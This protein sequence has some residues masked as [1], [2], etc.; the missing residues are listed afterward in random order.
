MTRPRALDLFCG[1]G[2]AAMGLHRAGF[3]IVGIDIEPQPNYPFAFIQADALAPPFDLSQFDFIWASPPCQFASAAAA[4]MRAR[5][6]EYPDLID[7][8]R[9][10]LA[11]SGA[12]TAME[13]V[14]QAPLRRDLIL[15]GTMFPPLR[16][17]RRRVFETN[18]FML[19][20]SSRVRP[21]LVTKERWST[22]A[23]GGR[24]SGVPVEANAWHTADACRKAMGIDWMPRRELSQAIPPAYSEFIGRAAL[25]HIGAPSPNNAS[26]GQVAADPPSSWCDLANSSDYLAGK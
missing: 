14:P 15:D 20:P 25:E 3:E 19:Q 23:G 16:V 13:N 2:G 21:N 24:A 4:Y 9:E 11:S 18:F 17:I 26:N 7:E 6:K 22:I 12:V 1:A 5:G 8:T 10:L